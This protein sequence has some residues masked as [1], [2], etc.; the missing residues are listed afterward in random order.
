MRLRRNSAANLELKHPS[1]KKINQVSLGLPPKGTVRNYGYTELRIHG[2]K[3]FMTNP[4][5]VTEHRI[6]REPY[7]I[8][9][10]LF[11][12]PVGA[13]LYLVCD[14]YLL[15]SVAPSALDGWGGCSGHVGLAPYANQC[16]TFS[17][18]DR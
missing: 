16:R 2:Y 14:A 7:Q 3:L 17:A 4:E 6:G 11:N 9:G 5:G 12:S 18:P 8:R 10:C 15:C 13:T 1:M